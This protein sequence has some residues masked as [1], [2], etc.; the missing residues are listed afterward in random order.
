[1]KKL[2]KVKKHWVAVSIGIVTS[3]LLVNNVAAN[4]VGGDTSEMLQPTTVTSSTI[5]KNNE[6]GN[7]LN[8]AENGN[9]P[10]SVTEQST[11]PSSNV[12]DSA[13]TVTETPTK[14]A[15]S[16]QIGRSGFRSVSA[17]TSAEK[18][19]SQPKESIPTEPAEPIEP[20]LKPEV[21]ADEDTIKAKAIPEIPKENQSKKIQD[22]IT[23]DVRTVV[24]KPTVEGIEYDVHYDHKN[25]W[26]YVNATD[27]GLNVADNQD[28]T[29]A[30]NKALK[31]A[32]EIVMA[33][34][35]GTQHTG[36][37]VKL[38]GIVNVARDKGEIDHYK[39]L[40][41]GSGVPMPIQKGRIDGVQDLSHV[42][43]EEYQ[44]LR[45]DSDG[46]VRYISSN[47]ENLT[48]IALPIYRKSES[49]SFN[50][51]KIGSEHSNVTGL[52]GDGPGTT[53]LKTNLVQLG[54]PWDSNEN[55]TDNRDHAVLL[56]E[57]QNGFLVKDLSV[58]I[59][60]LKEAFGEQHDGFYVKGMPYYGK[61]D[62]VLINDSDNVTVENIEASGANKAGIRF[63]SSYNSVSNIS[64]PGWG[65]PRSVSNLIAGKAPGYTFSSLNLGEN[66][67][68]LNSNTHNNRVAGVQFS[69]QT[70]ILIEGTTTS[71]NGHKLNGSTGY[72]FASEAG[73][74][75]N[76]IVFR[77]NTS[78]YNYR[79]GLDIHDGDRILIENNISYGDRL[80]GIS[81]YNRNFKMENVVIRNNVVTQDKTNRLVRD[82]LKVDGK[83]TH[84]HDYLQYEAIH[85]QTNEK[86]QDLSADGAVG[87]FEISN[88]RIQDLDSSGR[89]ATNQDYN[90]NAILVRMQEPY[91]NYVLNIK[92]NQITGHSANDLIKMIN[93]SNDNIRGTAT[94]SDTSKFANGLGYG[95]GSINISNNKVE[96]EELYGDPNKDLSAITIAEST[97]NFNVA[98]KTIR[99]NQ[100]KFRGSV[101]FQNN[102][103]KVKK[104]FMS[105][106]PGIIG[107]QKTMPIISITTNAEGVLF[108]DNN[109]DFG[110][111]TQ[112]LAKNAATQTP[113]ISLNGNNGT[114]V[115]PGIGFGIN[116]TRTPS[117]LP[118]TLSRTQPL[119]FIGN[120]IK[121]SNISY[122]NNVDLPIRVLEANHLVRYT[123][124]NTFTSE[125]EITASTTDTKTDPL[126]NAIYKPA[127][128]RLTPNKEKNSTQFNMGVSR[129]STSSPRLVNS[130]EETIPY[131]TIYVNDKTIAAGTSIE[132]TP[133]VAGTK[134]VNTY[135]TG[136]DNSAYEK[137]SGTDILNY[138][139]RYF[140]ATTNIREATDNDRIPGLLRADY[141]TTDG[142]IMTATKAYSYTDTK[143]QT[144]TTE[145]IYRY[146][147][148]PIGLKNDTQYT[149]TDE[150][151]T[152]A[153][154]SRIVHVG[155]R[156]SKA[157]GAFDQFDV[158]FETEYVNDD[159]ILVGDSVIKT[160]G[161]K[162]IRTVSYREIRDND[163][164]DLIS[165]EQVSDSITTKPIKQIV[166]V[167]TK[168][169]TVTTQ[170]T[171]K[172]DIDFDIVKV[173]SDKLFV[174]EEDIQ[175][176][177]VKGTRTIVHEDTIDN[178]N[179]TVISSRVISDEQ[180]EPVK[181]IVL[182]GTKP[183]TRTAQ[184]TEKQDIDFD[185][186][187]VPSD[188]LFVGEEEIQTPGVKG[189]RTI[190]HEDTI[191]NRNNTVISS[192]VISDEQT[193]P[194]KQIVLVGTKPLTVTTQ[195]TEKQDIDFDIVKVPSDKLFVGEEEIQTP[196]VKGTRTIVHEDTIDNRNNTVISSRVVSDEQTEPVKQIVLV[197]T[198]PLTRTVQRTI[199]LSIP[200]GI[201]SIYD[202]KLPSGTQIIVAPG[203][204]GLRTI[205][206][207]EVFDDKGQIIS[208]NILSST[209]TITPTDEIVRIGTAATT[210]TT[211]NNTDQLSQDSQQN[212]ANTEQSTVDNTKV[213]PN[214]GTENNHSAAVTG[215]L[216]LFAALGLTLFKR[217]EEDND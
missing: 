171:E 81:V 158:D 84:G 164:N 133:G 57:N 154:Q 21:K 135:A 151:V 89:T 169:L 111:I 120:D 196:G 174:G 37:A 49:G 47:G 88:N 86:S 38:S 207:E 68:V 177:G 61:V 130:S 184:R 33:D 205:I 8:S 7:T 27:F 213:L 79:K 107:K 182:V 10:S 20:A 217:K 129:F 206:I 67:K 98:D 92:N 74:Y 166:L 201:Q 43:K 101:V 25:K 146:E 119:A 214:T 15:D 95:S 85:L 137:S 35:D 148:L 54:N 110:K 185:I 131:E 189:I 192:R 143:K 116:T 2:R 181:Q 34:P 211:P 72:G 65:R 179:N 28:D 168:P 165:R 202:D 153:P 102:D 99:A 62:G 51:I 132:K 36:V 41:Y 134:T 96:L 22:A 45:V 200:Y 23:E 173:P 30:V 159:T 31:A 97:S 215:A 210:A 163:T 17:S 94:L 82:D 175:T 150:N 103:I 144:Q 44:N 64:L 203:K 26:Y 147:N 161:V 208:S 50:Q 126:G 66:N 106:R 152:T 149:F 75:N 170:R 140:Y 39:I 108:K 157:I 124:N 56:V 16:K 160:P 118:N 14:P 13:S 48:G 29:L 187:K 93:S 194:V 78:T 104:T 19:K 121:I 12:S 186:V 209:V 69:Y 178:R 155:T 167:G 204:A 109:L 40:T 117:N 83:F 24:S 113:L 112:S 123:E 190:V 87:Y 122:A 46:L 105:T 59:Q 9:N 52:F 198:K 191:D 125:S 183:L 63:G 145:M 115:Q 32:N 77:N 80:L 197:G 5:E 139:L 127:T 71:E 76:G 100:D 53:V 128:E 90:T 156:T 1:M 114:L 70:N 176:P 188:K 142:N 136:V 195:R 58:S 60:N 172:Q 11:T 193:E 162:G 91:L 42:T 199:E 18:N 6:D 212:H 138:G 73:S 3:A 55:D 180:T 216:A 141:T 4:E